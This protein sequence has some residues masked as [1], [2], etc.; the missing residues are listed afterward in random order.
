MSEGG[1]DVPSAIATIKHRCHARFHRSVILPGFA[2][3][4]KSHTV[5]GGLSTGRKPV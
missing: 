4:P 2:C 3:P 5:K 1:N